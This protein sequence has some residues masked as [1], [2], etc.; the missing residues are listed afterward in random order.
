MQA[1]VM[2]FIDIYNIAYKWSYLCVFMCDHVGR[3]S[4]DRT[5]LHTYY[6]S[7]KCNNNNRTLNCIKL[8]RNAFANSAMES[9][10][11]THGK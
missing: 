9:D 10:F 6:V 2:S 3:I 4:P 7:Y 1:K 5:C 11:V 8:I